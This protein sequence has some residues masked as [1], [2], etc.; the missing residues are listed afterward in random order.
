[1]AVCLA[2]VVIGFVVPVAVLLSFVLQG[3]SVALDVTVIEAAGNSIFIG[4]AA[5]VLVIATAALIGLTSMFEK[6]VW[7]PRFSAL[8][9][10]G[11][12]FPGTILAI[13][14]VTAGGAVDRGIA[15]LF[16]LTLG[17]SYEGWLTSG[18]GLIIFACVVRFQAVGYGAVMTGLGRVAPSMMEVYTVGPY[19]CIDY[20]GG[21][22]HYAGFSTYSGRIHLSGP[23]P[24]PPT[25]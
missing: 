21:P 15:E 18:V 19:F 10:F 25:H 5:A 24:N 8:A 16:D 1:M 20:A 14:V 22:C 3:Y 4:L 11:Y 9:S 6:G 17:V 12:A 23:P 7:L 13:G 2:P